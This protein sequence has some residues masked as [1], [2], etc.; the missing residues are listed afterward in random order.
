M[1]K[2]NMP[3]R[4]LIPLVL[5]TISIVAVQ[6]AARI[7]AW[8]THP[9][10]PA[11]AFAEQQKITAADGTPGDEFGFI[12][13]SGSTVV[14]GSD[15]DDVDVNTN[16]GSAY[17]FEREGQHLIQRQKLAASDGGAFDSFGYA[18]AISGSTM[19]VGSFKDDVGGNVDQGSA[20]VFERQGNQWVEKAKL[21]AS[22]G[23]SSD[24]FGVAT[25]IAGNTI[26]VSA[27]G[28]DVGGNVE[29][30]SVYVFELHA[31]T[32]CSNRNLQRW[33]WPVS[34]YQRRNDNGRCS[35]R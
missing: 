21:T 23:A 28:D 32:G 29:Q 20:Y 24:E 34:R 4:S 25:A 1:K 13:I 16:Q 9:L 2:F 5:A 27:R 12:A 19:V 35:V 17:V 22:D 3:L 14:I 26:A 33:F 18:V 8:H 6:A 31:R 10:A 30:G 7:S 15:S 11:P